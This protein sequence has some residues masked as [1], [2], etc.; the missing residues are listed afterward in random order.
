MFCSRLLLTRQGPGML[1]CAALLLSR[2]ALADA[3]G[4]ET[5]GPAASDDALS[6]TID[7]A[8]LVREALA[9]NP[10]LKA[11]AARVRAMQAMSHAEGKLPDP[12]VMFQTWQVPL[13]HPLSLVDSQMIMTGVT[14]TIPAPGSLSGRAEARDHAATAEEAVLADRARELVRDVQHAYA[15][16][17]EAVALHHTHVGHHGVAARLEAAARARQAGGGPLDDVVQAELGVA[18]LDADVASEAA[19]I[20][21]AKARL[22]G[23]LSRPYDAPLADPEPGG[24]ETTSMTPEA[25][26][27]LAARTRPDLRAASAREDSE[28][29]ALAS[30]EREASL[31]SFTVGAYYFAPTNLMPINGY[32]VSASMSLPWIWRGN[33]GKAESQRAT[34]QASQFD[35]A[36]ARQRIGVDIGTAYATVQAAAARLRALQSGALPAARRAL[37]ATFAT[38]ASGRGDLLGV[39]RAQQAVVDTEMDSAQARAS[40]DHALADLDWGVGTLVPRVPF[41]SQTAPAAHLAH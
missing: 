35:V 18:R 33:A 36:D 37:D 3:G 15:D 12:E 8:I 22:N 23:F 27:Q 20:T 10:G 1:C 9:R 24:P 30:A 14:Q 21:R 28:R 6:R 31:P 34:A 39:V 25:L 19:S 26:V 11:G 38:Y 32:G 16:L 5:D 17:T 7:R 41:D 13:A 29:A 40:L 4:T 2:P